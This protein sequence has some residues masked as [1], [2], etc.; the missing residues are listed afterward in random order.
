M[1]IIL[2]VV[3]RAQDLAVDPVMRMKS[4]PEAGEIIASH[5]QQSI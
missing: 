3:P 1:P 4:K 2:A 5:G